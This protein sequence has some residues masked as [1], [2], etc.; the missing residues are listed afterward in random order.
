[1]TTEIPTIEQRPLTKEAAQSLR[2]GQR[3]HQISPF[4]RGGKIIAVL[5]DEPGGMYYVCRFWYPVKRRWHYNVHW[6]FDFHIG[7][8]ALG[9]QPRVRKVTPA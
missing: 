5:P 1:M 7:L 8:V 3:V 4:G 9:P 6:W 2:V